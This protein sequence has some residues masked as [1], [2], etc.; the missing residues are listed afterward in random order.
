MYIYI[1]IY[2]L[3]VVIIIIIIITT[4]IPVIIML[5]TQ[6]AYLRR[7]LGVVRAI[8]SLAGQTAGANNTTMT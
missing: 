1:Y 8:C 6:A 4:T 3:V 7:N 2:V 5:A